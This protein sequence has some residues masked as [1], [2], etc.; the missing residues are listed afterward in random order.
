MGIRQKPHTGIAV[1]SNRAGKHPHEGGVVAV[2][3]KQLTPS[4]RAIQHMINYPA[5][6]MSRLSRHRRKDNRKRLDWQY[7]TCP[8]IRSRYPLDIPLSARSSA[9]LLQKNSTS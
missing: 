4:G 1:S 3:G 6:S 5:R 8:V 9:G 2:I 7:W